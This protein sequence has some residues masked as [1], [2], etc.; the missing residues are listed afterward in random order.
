MTNIFM[1]ETT[2]FRECSVKFYLTNIISLENDM[3]THTKFY[4]YQTYFFCSICSKFTIVTTHINFLNRYKLKKLVARKMLD[5]PKFL[6]DFKT[7]FYSEKWSLVIKRHLTITSFS[8]NFIRLT[9]RGMSSWV[10]NERVTKDDSE[11]VLTI[12]L[13][14]MMKDLKVVKNCSQMVQ[15]CSKAEIV[16][17]L[18]FWNSQNWFSS[19]WDLVSFF[20]KLARFSLDCFITMGSFFGG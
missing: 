11:N 4:R 20:R 19:F 17:N 3:H 2:F 12:K 10:V 18:K 6:L 14:Q 8:L 9:Y 15:L 7:N 16:H 1:V 13:E 5:F